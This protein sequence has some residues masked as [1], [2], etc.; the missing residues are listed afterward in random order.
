MTVRVVCVVPRSLRGRGGIERLFLFASQTDVFER[1]GVAMSYVTVRGPGSFANWAG[2]FPF[3]LARAFLTVLLSGCEVVHI[4]LAPN[5]SAYRK[6]VFF[7]LVRLLRKK[8]VIHFHSG[9]FDGVAFGNALSKRIILHLFRT[10]DRA[11]L[12]GDR[13]RDPFVRESGR[14][15]Q[16]IDV[17]PNGIPDF[18][19]ETAAR[20]S[21]DGT[22]RIA[23]AGDLGHHKGPDILI[24]GRRPS[25]TGAARWPGRATPA[26]TRPWP[27]RPGS[28]GR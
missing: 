3:R 12:L 9:G 15:A 26:R 22:L 20:R 23:F 27:R 8:T 10:A 4:N 1:H 13:F 6:I 16:A 25:K 2:L 11:I 5:S 17:V 7:Y 18:R 14:S 19:D 24:G 21:D 28:P